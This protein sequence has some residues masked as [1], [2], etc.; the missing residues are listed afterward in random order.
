MSFQSNAGRWNH[1]GMDRR[2]CLHCDRI[3][4]RSTWFRH[5]RPG[6]AKDLTLSFAECEGEEISPERAQ[7]DELLYKKVHHNCSNKYFEWHIKTLNLPLSSWYLFQN[8]YSDII[9]RS[10][11]YE[12]CVNGCYLFKDDEVVC[13]TCNAVRPKG[14]DRRVFTY[15]PISSRLQQLYNNHTWARL[16]RYPWHLSS[17][18]IREVEGQQSDICNSWLWKKVVRDCKLKEGDI[19]FSLFSDSVQVNRNRGL[20]HSITP[21]IIKLCNLPPWI[22]HKS[23]FQVC[24]GLVP[25]PTFRNPQIYM[26]MIIDEICHL[27]EHGILIV[28]DAATGERFVNR[29]ATLL[30]TSNDLRAIPKLNG[31]YQ[32]P[33][34]KGA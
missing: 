24:V 17:F 19:L 10:I 29:R 27:N 25:G 22:R 6:D 15:F 3:V 18:G 26:S 21:I 23:E 5:N 31:Q 30:H 11:E 14:R 32:Q 34:E 16:L 28:H 2:L 9:P 13:P 20:C 7:M 33:A 4:S 8:H 12:V 1:V